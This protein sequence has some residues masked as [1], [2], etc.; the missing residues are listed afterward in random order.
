MVLYLKRVYLTMTSE[1]GCYDQLL[2][3]SDPTS[4]RN[5][6]VVTGIFK[7]AASRHLLELVHHHRRQPC[8]HLHPP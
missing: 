4:M 3:S 1:C 2:P 5:Q 8:H 6:M 7:D